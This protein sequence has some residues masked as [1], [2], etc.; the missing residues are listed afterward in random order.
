MGH[1]YL[2][3][4]PEKYQQLPW[5]ISNKLLARL[6][7]L[8]STSTA[9]SCNC[10]VTY[11]GGVLLWPESWSHYLKNVK[12]SWLSVFFTICSSFSISSYCKYNERGQSPKLIVRCICVMWDIG[13]EWS[14][15]YLVFLS[16]PADKLFKVLTLSSCSSNTVK[17]ENRI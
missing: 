15:L 11:K 1:L 16:W 2:A 7:F 10:L 13:R 3:V 5:G 14:F 12:T 4:L 9:S 17:P 6:F 8:S